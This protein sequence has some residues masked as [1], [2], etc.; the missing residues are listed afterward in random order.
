MTYD[1]EVYTDDG[2][3]L[4]EVFGGYPTKELAALEMKRIDAIDGV[5]AQIVQSREVDASWMDHVNPADADYEG[6]HD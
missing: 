4:L 2:M 3:N 1:V 6:F 5:W